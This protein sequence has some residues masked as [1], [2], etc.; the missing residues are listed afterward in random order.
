MITVGPAVAP[1]GVLGRLSDS[2]S[3]ARLRLGGFS[4]APGWPRPEDSLQYYRGVTTS[5][6]DAVTVTAA[7]LRAG[8]RQRGSHGPPH[9]DVAAVTVTVA[10]ATLGRHY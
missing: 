8:V 4:T 3:P 6:S 7:A 2:D 9:R 5:L 10:P 1:S